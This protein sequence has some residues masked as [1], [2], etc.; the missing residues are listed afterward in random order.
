MGRRNPVYQTGPR[1]F[2]GFL[3]HARKFPSKPPRS[4][5]TKRGLSHLLDTYCMASGQKVNKE[6]SS[7]FFS[8][9]TPEILRD[10]VKGFLHVPNEYLSGRYLAMP[11]DVGH[12]KN[13]TFNYLSERVWDKVKGW[14]SKC[15][16]AGGK[17]VLI[18]SVAQAIP[19]YSMSCFKLPR[20]LCDHIKSI[21]RKFWWGCKQGE[22][23]PTWV[24]WDVMTRP[25][26]V[27]GLGFRDLELFNLALLARQAWRIFMEPSSLSAKI[28]KAS[29]FPETTL[30]EAELGSRPSQIWRA[31]LE[32]RDVLK[33]G[34][35]KLI[36]NGQNTDIWVDNWIPKETSSIELDKL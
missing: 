11:T 34:V 25:K 8:K 13:G 12:S 7:I 32:G 4:S 35:I 3:G 33:Q 23:K 9:G 6:K 30:L 2:A 27:G 28:L 20:G 19:V 24:S 10:A 5:P 1:G 31:I 26:H 14:M 21:I 36:G 16:S 15:L 18:K 29:Y 17:E 22:R